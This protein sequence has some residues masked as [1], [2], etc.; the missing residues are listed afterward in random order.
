ME[1]WVVWGGLGSFNG[2][3]DSCANSKVKRYR[4]QTCN[5]FSIDLYYSF[6]V[7]C[8]P[9]NS[10]ISMRLPKIYRLDLVH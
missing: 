9:H 4:A 3:H 5:C 7:G 10:S 6:K 8:G 1:V 2:P